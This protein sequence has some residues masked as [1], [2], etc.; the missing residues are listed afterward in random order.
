MFG[1]GAIPVRGRRF[2]L[3]EGIGAAHRRLTNSGEWRASTGC[4]DRSTSVLGSPSWNPSIVWPGRGNGFGW[5]PTEG[6]S[7]DGPNSLPGHARPQHCSLP[8]ADRRRKCPGASNHG[9]EGF[10]P[11]KDVARSRRRRSLGSSFLL[12]ARSL[13]LARVEPT[14]RKPS[15][16]TGDGDTAHCRSRVAA[17]SARGGLR[18]LDLRMSQ[19]RGSAVPV[20][21]MRTPHRSSEPYECGAMSS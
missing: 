15:P 16:G 9:R 11:R 14:G 17:R 12:H 18:T 3:L 13:T 19:V 6:A 2:L 7:R 21:D 1:A 4:T 5:V 20:T 10:E 8:F